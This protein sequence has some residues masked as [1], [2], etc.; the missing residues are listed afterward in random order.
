MRDIPF[1]GC[2]RENRA[3]LA[4]AQPVFSEVYSSGMMLE[5][6]WV[7]AFEAEVAHRAGRAHGVALGSATDGLYLALKCLGIGPGDEVLTTDFSFIATAAAILRVGAT[8]VFAD[9]GSACAIDFTR[10]A[11]RVGPRCK[12]LLHVPLFGGMTDPGLV[13][14]FA[15]D[16]GLLLIED[17]AQAFGASYGARAAG[18]TGHAS[19]FS[20]DPTKVLNAPGSG[21]AV[22]TDDAAMARRLRRLRNHGKE[23][24]GF[25]EAGLNS[26]MPSLAAALCS[27]KLRHLPDWAKTRAKI[28]ASYDGALRAKG[29]Q[30]PL[31]DDAVT[32]AW[33]K[34]TFLAP[35][36]DRLRAHLAA[37]GV[38]SVVHY[39]LPFHREPMF[40]PALADDAFPKATQISGQI[41][42]LPIH[43]QITDD[44]LGQILTAVESF[45]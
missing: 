19:V 34:Y 40:G 17:A 30:R 31:W 9:I 37:H 11:D 5:G 24:S 35:E 4:E 41:L 6:P 15:D 23:G 14:A 36:R 43:G 7:S 44:E 32:H 21:G 12:A 42:S 27:L 16:H 26:K 10:A 25:A 28:A 29:W 3:L 1:H 13:E 39:P 22:V 8:P 33:H 38:P 2:L 20:F 45:A 18:S